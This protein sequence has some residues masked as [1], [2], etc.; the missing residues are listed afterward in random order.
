MSQ[1]ADN[2]RLLPPTHYNTFIDS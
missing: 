1:V 2:D